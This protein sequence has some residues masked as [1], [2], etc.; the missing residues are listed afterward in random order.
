MS[1]SRRPDP[2]NP[3]SEGRPQLKLVHGQVLPG[4]PGSHTVGI[5]TVELRLPAGT[6][7]LAV[8]RTMTAAWA[9]LE[10]W[11]DEAVADLALAVDEACTALIGMA[12]A[13]ASLVLVENSRDRELTIRLSTACDA[14]DD[15]PANFVLSGFSRRV[16]EALT[17]EVDT[18]VGDEEGVGP[19]FGIALTTR[20]PCA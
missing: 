14:P 4:D 19:V 16:L 18:F 15:D 1:S 20:R 8:V 12:A 2:G 10:G 5:H 13:G 3:D 6:D 7:M 9:G 11:G 17:D